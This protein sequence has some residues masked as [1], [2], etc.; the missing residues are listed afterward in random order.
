MTREGR[1]PSAADTP[2]ARARTDVRPRT[3][4]C[5]IIAGSQEARG[6]ELDRRETHGNEDDQ[7]LLSPVES[8]RRKTHP[9]ED[10]DCAQYQ[11]HFGAPPYSRTRRRTQFG[12]DERASFTT[13]P[14]ILAP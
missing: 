4:S 13:M 7:H 6:R 14:R 10:E 8:S 12:T 11:L 2:A 3:T 5:A 9:D 1:P